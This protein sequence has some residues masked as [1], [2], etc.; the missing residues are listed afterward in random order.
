MQGLRL[1]RASD[2]FVQDDPKGTWRQGD[3][4]H[5]S[6]LAE[7]HELV[8]LGLARLPA[9]VTLPPLEAAAPAAAI[10]TAS[11]SGGDLPAAEEAATRRPRDRG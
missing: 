2:R 11:L 9:G 10:E 5:V 8:R 4:F 1:L 3:S 6:T 7:A